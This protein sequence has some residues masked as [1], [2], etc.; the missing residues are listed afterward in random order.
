MKPKI[1]SLIATMQFGTADINDLPTPDDAMEA[2][3]AAERTYP[4]MVMCESAQADTIA[5]IVNEELAVASKRLD[6][7]LQAAG[8]S[9]V[10]TFGAK[11]G[12]GFETIL[13]AV[14]HIHDDKHPL[15]RATFLR[16]LLDYAQYNAIVG[17]MMRAT[18]QGLVEDEDKVKEVT[19]AIWDELY[20]GDEETW[21][22]MREGMADVM[23]RYRKH[24]SGD[25]GCAAHGKVTKATPNAALEE[26]DLEIAKLERAVKAADELLELAGKEK[27]SDRAMGIHKQ[28]HEKLAELQAARAKLASTKAEDIHS[29][30]V[31]ATLNVDG[32]IPDAI[33][34]Q[35]LD[36]INAGPQARK[37]TREELVKALA[38]ARV[39]GMA[40][41]SLKD[42]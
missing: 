1:G 34:D 6:D 26:L 11:V 40:V 39:G 8:V 19:S 5:K 32:S 30:V 13:Q 37:V 12:F 24:L 17:T 25:C 20:R 14:D 31:E 38:E 33:I 7:R 36:Q 3:E 9:K 2:L 18:E 15:L 27:I 16:S 35:M 21:Q 29:G 23:E 41:I 22:S 42:N 4:Q 10:L 28:M